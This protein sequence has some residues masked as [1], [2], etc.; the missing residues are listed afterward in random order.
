ML[1]TEY[2]FELPQG[3]VDKTGNLHKKG[4]M[5]LASAADEIL[6]LKDPRVQ[7]NPAYLTILILSR[8]VTKLGDLDSIGTSTIENLFSADF[9]HL[10]GLYQEINNPSEPLEVKCPH[11]GESHEIRPFLARGQ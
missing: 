11:C 7:Q 5:R 3:F 1:Q 2:Q 4:L 6:P 8:V 10:Q 9:N